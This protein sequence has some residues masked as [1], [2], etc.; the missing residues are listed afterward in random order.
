MG[1]PHWY[2][3]YNHLTFSKDSSSRV[4]RFFLDSLI[5]FLFVKKKLPGILLFGALL[6]S[7]VNIP[8]R[9]GLIDIRNNSI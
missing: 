4:T 9:P 2:S 5:S 7:Q 6:D 1:I 3:E 8:W